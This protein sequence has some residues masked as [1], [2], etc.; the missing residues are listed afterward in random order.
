MRTQLFCPEC[1]AV[2]ERSKFSAFL[3]T[4]DHLQTKPAGTA[5]CFLF[6]RGLQLQV[7]SGPGLCHRRVVWIYPGYS[8]VCGYKG[9]AGYRSGAKSAGGV[10]RCVLY[11]GVNVTG[12]PGLQGFIRNISFGGVLLEI[13]NDSSNVKEE[14]LKYTNAEMEVELNSPDGLHKMNFSGI[15]K[16]YKKVKKKDNNTLYLN[17][18][19]HNLDDK[20][21]DVLKKYLSLSSGDKNL[22]WNL[23]DNL[24]MQP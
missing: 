11:G 20:S 17:I 19:F 7:H 2:P 23:W 24:S 15:I 14:L 13:M 12:L 5:G 1:F 18:Q 16:W 3:H 21:A 22:F 8:T 9:K 10:P 6:A 4:L